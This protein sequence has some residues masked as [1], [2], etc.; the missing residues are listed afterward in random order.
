VGLVI[1]TSALVAL[2][3]AGADWS[4]ALPSEPAAIPAIVYAELLVGVKMA[5]GQRRAANRRAKIDALLETISIVGF[6]PPEAERWADVYAH[7]SR[8]GGLIPANDLVVAAIALEL[9]YG[10]LVGPGD[11]A[12][13]RRVPKLRVVVLPAKQSDGTSSA[14]A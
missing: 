12:H 14:G 10:V 4:A 9:E 5:D 3:R 1:D 7:L 6:G 2:E 8:T 11:E 13:F